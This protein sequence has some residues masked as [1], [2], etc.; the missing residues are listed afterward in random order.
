MPQSNVS[1]SRSRSKVCSAGRHR[2]LQ[3]Q[4]ADALPRCGMKA[5]PLPPLADRVSVN[6]PQP[7]GMP[8]AVKHG[9]QHVRKCSKRDMRFILKTIGLSP[10]ETPDEHSDAYGDLVVW[11][12]PWRWLEKFDNAGGDFN[13]L[14][15]KPK[16][17]EDTTI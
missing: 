10:A 13:Q 5:S 16:F 2:S 8:W 3:K 14:S 7:L 1:R 15:I 11:G 6:A 17:Q 4:N 12:R 9:F